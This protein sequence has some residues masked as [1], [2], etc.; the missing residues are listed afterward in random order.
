MTDNTKPKYD[1]LRHYT[2]SDNRL[3]V[4]DWASLA[5]HILH[6]PDKGVFIKDMSP[7]GGYSFDGVA[8]DK[9]G[10]YV[11]YGNTIY[12]LTKKGNV[13][14]RSIVDSTPEQLTSLDETTTR[15]L[16]DKLPQ[17]FANMEVAQ[18]QATIWMSKMLEEVINIVQI[19]NPRDV[20]IALEGYD[21]WRHGVYD[22]YY[23]LPGKVTLEKSD[24]MVIVKYDLAEIMLVMDGDN[25]VETINK[26]SRANK[27]KNIISGKIRFNERYETEKFSV[28]EFTDILP[29]L[30]T[31]I[32]KD[33]VPKY[34]GN[35]KKTEWTHAF[36][37]S[38]WN[39][40]RN[41]CAKALSNYMN[42][43]VAQDDK[44]EGDDIANVAIRENINN[45][46]DMVL[47][48]RDSDMNQLLDI[49]NLA[50]YNHVER[51][52]L[53]ELEAHDYLNCKIL[54]GDS[55]DNIP[56]MLVNYKYSSKTKSFNMTPISKVSSIASGKA[57]PLYEGCGFNPYQKSVDDNWNDQFERNRTL[58]DLSRLPKELYF[59]LVDKIKIDGW[60]KHNVNY[61]FSEKVVEKLQFLFDRGYYI[62]HEGKVE[63]TGKR[64]D[65]PIT[66]SQMTSS[67][68]N[69][70]NNS[71]GNAPVMEAPIDDVGWN[72]STDGDSWSEQSQQPWANEGIDQSNDGWGKEDL[73]W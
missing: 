72:V 7:M 8:Y 37:K 17:E 73:Q 4:F 20:V 67:N 43:K 45:Y 28:V 46:K 31:Y 52:V 71:N 47:V 38:E 44:C 3:L 29:E 19:F 11:R 70:I 69:V 5:M 55:G 24:T 59:A 64:Y 35:R 25:I 6:A 21:N 2:Y 14:N 15:A 30:S 13:I 41:N 63:F 36:N 40:I 62:L 60:E 23:K 56:G 65:S 49:K 16:I 54:G 9:T 22:E 1:S 58:I 32:W 26:G 10:Y 27:E 50:I 53:S 18:F 34:K 33:V 61:S 12:Q 39:N 66:A 51:S 68:I 48:T 57:N 42:V